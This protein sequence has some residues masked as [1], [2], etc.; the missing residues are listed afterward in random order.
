[1]RK[2]MMGWMVTTLAVAAVISAA[3]DLQSQSSTGALK[4]AELESEAYR[5]HDQP[6]QW[7]YAANLYMAAV[8][9]RADEDPQAQE[10]LLLAAAL[11]YG[12]GDAAS[13]IAA[14]ESAGSRVLAGGDIVRAAG[15]FTDAAWVAGKAGLRITLSR[16]SSRA[17]E[18]A[19][20]PELTRAEKRRILSRFR[21]AEKRRI[22]S[23]FRGA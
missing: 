19:D 3:S 16:L 11:G 15:I 8:Q 6:R 20:S 21:G 17:I 12:T 9:L 18:L 5:L 13:A 4:A 1:M 14:L 2:I 23:R 22:L 10:D 7:A